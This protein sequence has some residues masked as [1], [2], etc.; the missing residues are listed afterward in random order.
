MRN[1]FGSY[2]STNHSHI[3]VHRLLDW[4]ES[5]RIELYSK[6]SEPIRITKT[7]RSQIIEN[8]LLGIPSNSV[9]IEQEHFGASIVLQGVEI[10]ETISSFVNNEFRLTELR[11]FNHLNGCFFDSMR[12]YE[13]D[14]L[15]SSE[16]QMSEI[17][18]DA[19]PRLKC[20]FFRNLNQS[21]RQKNVSQ[22]ARNY[23]FKFAYRILRDCSESLMNNFDF[24]MSYQDSRDRTKNE[25]RINEFILTVILMLVVSHMKP[26][27]IENRFHSE[28]FLSNELYYDDVIEIAL[29]KIMMSIDLNEISIGNYYDELIQLVM[30]VLNKSHA[31]S[32]SIRDVFSRGIHPG[33]K[34]IS[35]TDLLNLIHKEIFGFTPGR[36]VFSIRDKRRASTVGDLLR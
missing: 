24:S 23:A 6:Y 1:N 36:D 17:K 14:M 28:D 21:D 20:E 7:K 32:I 8:L 18:Y 9:W 16:L 12:Y 30:L 4:L 15:L 22:L 25:A 27:S 34:I 13:H 11:Y 19:H 10:L 33:N 35:L 5:E 2:I 3:T 29:D 31:D 26:K